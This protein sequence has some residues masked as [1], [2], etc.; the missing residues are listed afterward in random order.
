MSVLLSLGWSQLWKQVSRNNSGGVTNYH[1][2]V[3]VLELII[4]LGW[5]KLSLWLRQ[6]MH[7]IFRG[8]EHGLSVEATEVWAT[9]VD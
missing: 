7:F 9:L 3:I 1:F 4:D 8:L 2:Q 5:M 6:V